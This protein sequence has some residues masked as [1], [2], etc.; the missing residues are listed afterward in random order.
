MVQ[1]DSKEAG[2]FTNTMHKQNTLMLHTTLVH[3]QDTQQA[4]PFINTMHKHDTLMLHTTLTHTREHTNP[5]YSISQ[6]RSPCREDAY[7]HT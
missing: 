4:G 2:P 7:P 6:H 3:T 1:S 5:L